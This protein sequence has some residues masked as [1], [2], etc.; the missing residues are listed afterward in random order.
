M[1]V[2]DADAWPGGAHAAPAD[3]VPAGAAPAV[4]QASPPR[5]GTASPGWAGEVG[6]PD[7]V[8]RLAGSRAAVVVLCAP[9]GFGKTAVLSRWARADERAVAW[10]TIGPEHRDAGQLADDLLGLVAA[11]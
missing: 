7:P 2:D 5:T 6:R 4:A 1:G 3:A 10:L 8:R 11:L 9:A